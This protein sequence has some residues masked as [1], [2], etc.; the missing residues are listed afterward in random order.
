MVHIA[1]LDKEFNANDW[2]AEIKR[3]Y[4]VP[5]TVLKCLNCNRSFKP[6]IGYRR[7]PRGCTA[8]YRPDNHISGYCSEFEASC[9]P[10]RFLILIDFQTM[11]YFFMIYMTTVSVKVV[12]TCDIE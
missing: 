1:W 9:S 7:D 5:S 3:K 6:E 12:L 4:R 11:K 10:W 2:S 8:I